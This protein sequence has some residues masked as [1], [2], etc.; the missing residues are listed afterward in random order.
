[1]E[2]EEIV[3]AI[4]LIEKFIKSMSKTGQNKNKIEDASAAL[5][6]LKKISID[7]AIKGKILEIS[8][9]RSTAGHHW[10]LVDDKMVQRFY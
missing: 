10:S 5:K 4:E 9:V 7:Y 6:S 2:Y 3:K 1:M 8:P